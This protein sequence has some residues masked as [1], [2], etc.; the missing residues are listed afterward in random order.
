MESDKRRAFL[1]ETNVFASRSQGYPS[2]ALLEVNQDFEA[3]LLMDYAASVLVKGIAGK[4]AR[5]REQSRLE[6]TSTKAD[7]NP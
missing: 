3:T 7:A 6:I 5:D 1:H 2:K 4:A